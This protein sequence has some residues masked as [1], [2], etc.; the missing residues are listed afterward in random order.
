[1]KLT[2]FFIFLLWAACA[3]AQTLYFT[4]SGTISFFSSAPLEDIEAKN[5]HVG[6]VLNLKDG[7]LIFKVSVIKFKFPNATMEE[8]FNENY[9][10]TEKYPN[11]DF[12]GRVMDF[13]N[14]DLTKDGKIN[15]V[16]TGDLT[17]HGVTNKVT[18]KGVLE[19]KGANITANAKFPIRVADY[20][21][22]IPRMVIKNVAEVVDVTVDL[23]YE[24]KADK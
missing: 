4:N 15:V 6:S 10:E 17:I 18:H 7:S 12:K 21:I 5:T 9:M 19:R 24:P 2:F 8:H 23:V 16:I 13:G 14:V 20:K 3:H 1:M 11:A 22:D